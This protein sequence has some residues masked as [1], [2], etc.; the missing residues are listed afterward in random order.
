MD[1]F[2]SLIDWKDGLPWTLRVDERQ[3]RVALTEAKGATRSVEAALCLQEHPEINAIYR[4][5]R[6]QNGGSHLARF[7]LNQMV[8]DPCPDILQH[9]EFKNWVNDIA[10]RG[11]SLE[12]VGRLM[13]DSFRAGDIYSAAKGWFDQPKGKNVHLR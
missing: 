1:R 13:G 10:K 11:L 2:H 7:L 4:L 5:A 9:A 8:I 12:D 6:Y 3:K